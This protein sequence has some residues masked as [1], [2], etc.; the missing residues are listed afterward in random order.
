V[1]A[2]RPLGPTA[3]VPVLR[4]PGPKQRTGLPGRD[5]IV[6]ELRERWLAHP[7]QTLHSLPGVGKTQ[8]AARLLA[9]GTED[10]LVVACLRG[11]EPGLVED[12]RALAADLG[13]AVDDDETVISSLRRWL[14]QHDSW[15]LVFDD[16][17]NSTPIA[18]LLPSAPNGIVL[19]TTT[20]GRLRDLGPLRQLDPLEGPV[21]AEYL[22]TRSGRPD[23]DGPSLVL[24]GRLGGLPLALEQCAAYAH[25]TGTDL[26]HYLRLVDARADILLAAEP[27][28]DEYG[29][30]VAVTVQ[31]AVD[32]AESRR[33]GAGALL[34]RLS[35]LGGSPIPRDLLDQEAA[36]DLSTSTVDRRAGVRLAGRPTTRGDRRALAGCPSRQGDGRRRA[37]RRSGLVPG[38]PPRGRPV[39]RSGS[40]AL[41]TVRGA[42]RTHREH[43]RPARRSRSRRPGDRMA[44]RSARNLPRQPRQPEPGARP[45]RT[46]WKSHG[47][48]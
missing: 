1:L 40:D 19:V 24:A 39:R 31:L 7:V 4:R 23:E 44:A 42:L 18:R 34:T 5:S 16:A 25:Q 33:A 12:A 37:R 47:R 14:E 15:L 20:N 41:A 26:A 13:L 48:R 45:V 27:T 3:A 8:V 43:L 17:P 29:R 32:A 22:R 10:R 46:V 35:C 28:A 21:A 36:E 38:P 6:R 30:T 2:R 9:D 11:A